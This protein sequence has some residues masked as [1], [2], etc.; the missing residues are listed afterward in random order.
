[1]TNLRMVRVIDQAFAA[2]NHLFHHLFHWLVFSQS[3]S[4]GC[5][6]QIAA[7]SS[8]DTHNRSKDPKSHQI[9]QTCSRQSTKFSAAPDSSCKYWQGL[10]VLKINSTITFHCLLKSSCIIVS[11][12]KNCSY[13]QHWYLN[14]FRNQWWWYSDNDNNDSVPHS[15]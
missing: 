3:T 14:L 12:I 6:T 11:V 15:G 10:T 1:M 5:S 2:I 4:P 9:L 8:V 7:S 13:L